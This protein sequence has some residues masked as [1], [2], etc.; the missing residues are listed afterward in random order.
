MSKY[1]LG[2]V[3]K[4]HVQKGIKEG[5]AQVCHGKKSPLSKMKADD[6]LVYYSPKQSMQSSEPCKAFTAIGKVKTGKIYQVEMFPG[7]I[8]FRL[9]IEYL[10]CNEISIA[11]LMDRLELTKNKNWGFMLKRGLLELS[12]VDFLTISHAMLKKS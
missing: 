12:E 5:F 4:E 3:S 2:V 7:F 8:P 10:P 6:W 9:D 11:N 1:W